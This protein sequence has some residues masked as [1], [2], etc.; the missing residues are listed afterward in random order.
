MF[1]KYLKKLFEKEKTEDILEIK[2]EVKILLKS[3]IDFLINYID[4]LG[5]IV[6]IVTDKDL[7][8][9][10]TN[11]T[12]LRMVNFD[13][14][15]GK[16]LKIFLP[17]YVKHLPIPENGMREKIYLHLK[18][19]KPDVNICLEGYVL[20]KNDMLL[21]FL[22]KRVYVYHELYE[23]ISELNNEI[24]EL[25]RESKKKDIIIEKLQNEIKESL[26]KDYLTGL[27]NRSYFE[28][29][30]E[31]EINKLKRYKIP[32][33]L[34]LVDVENFKEVN[35]SYGRTTGDRVLKELAKLLYENTRIVDMVFRMEEDNFII[36]LP[37]TKGEGANIVAEK[38]KKLINSTL[39]EGSISISVNTV[40]L[41]CTEQDTVESVIDR[42]YRAN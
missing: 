30:L 9:K 1:E 29:V 33:S 41:D 5:N 16:N 27:F 18:C 3:N 10:Y 35:Q 23:K 11:K 13:D 4:E 22:E 6:F 36:L 8:I 25:T 7:I 19:R 2:D 12:F 39:F 38:I 31:R 26:R 40:S 37:N 21:F 17:P 24:A 32:L 20:E 28:E 34:V 15:T 42:A 14:V